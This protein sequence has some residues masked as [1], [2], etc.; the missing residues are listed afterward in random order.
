[1]VNDFRTKSDS[2]V[3]DDDDDNDDDD[4]SIKKKSSLFLANTDVMMR[5]RLPQATAP[6]IMPGTTYR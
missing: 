6:S 5:C 1:M 3:D 2:C 4:V